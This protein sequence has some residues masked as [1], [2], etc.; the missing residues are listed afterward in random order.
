MAIE[1]VAEETPEKIFTIPININTGLT[2]ADLADVPKNL[3]LEGNADEI[4]EAFRSIYKVFETR[5]ADM[6]EINPMIRRKEGDIMAIDAKITIDSNAE[7]RQK[8]LA[9]A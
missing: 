4:K 8:D 9:E 7:F 5:D 6:V 2:D 3:G 1:D